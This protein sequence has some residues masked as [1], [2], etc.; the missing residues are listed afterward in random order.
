[1]SPIS[2]PGLVQSTQHASQRLGHGGVF[3]THVRRN[4]QHVGFNDPPRHADVFRISSVVEQKIF[5][6]VFLVFRAVEA[7]LARRGVQRD[8]SH[9]LLE[10]IHSGPDFFDYPGQ[11]MAKRAQGG[12]SCGHDSRANTLSGQYRRSGRPA[13]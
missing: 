5:A 4:Y 6:Q 3:E 11:F 1:M 12:R 2:T 10:A 7:H 9:A 8:H 13:L